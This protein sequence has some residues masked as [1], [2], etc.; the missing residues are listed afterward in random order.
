[1][2]DLDLKHLEQ[3]VSRE[4]FI[5][6]EPEIEAAYEQILKASEVGESGFAWFDWPIT[7]DREEFF[8]IQGLA[9]EIRERDE[10]FVLLGVGGSF[11][12]A[13]AL[14]EALSPNYLSEEERRRQYLPE[15]LFLGNNLS[16][17]YYADV[18]RYIG[19]RD[20]SLN[21][22]SKSGGTLETALAFRLL[23]KEL[24]QRYGSE[25]KQRIVCTT[26][27][28]KGKLKRLTEEK[29]YES[30]HIPPDIGG[31]YSVL[32]AVGLLPLAVGGIS[33]DNLLEGA[34]DAKLE[35]ERKT[36]ESMPFKYASARNILYRKGYKIE[37]LS[38]FE[39]NL[40]SFQEWWKQLFGESEG[41]GGKGIFPV[42]MAYSTDLHSLGQYM[43][44]GERIIME[45][46][47]NVHVSRENVLIPENSDNLDELNYLS[48][49]SLAEINTL[50]QAATALAH[51]DGGVPNLSINLEYL[52]ARHLGALVFFY[53]LAAAL[54]AYLQEANPF[55]QPGV[56][57]YKQNMF[58]LLGRADLAERAAELKLRLQAQ[59]SGL[60]DALR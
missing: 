7:Y 44:D 48:G 23:E 12:G 47:I 33:L 22:V 17:N 31:R 2:L 28:H 36:T 3:F 9:S 13:K 26:D 5:A 8:R 42:S 52:D 32:T 55:N 14:L 37:A 45:S 53:E 16:A 24:Y 10:V 19:E 43:Q 15:I 51:A 30:F 57:A 25:A 6:I 41:K 40:K 18:L 11:L 20:F 21:V 35:A 50:A 49:K 60:V 27:Q 29:G 54:S 56:E 46:F 59:K 4:D 1:M 58:A 38:C 39:P 34:Q